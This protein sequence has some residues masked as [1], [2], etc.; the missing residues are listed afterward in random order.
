VK[1]SAAT[2]TCEDGNEHMVYT[3]AIPFTDFPG[4]GITLWY[5]NNTILLPSEY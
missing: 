4:A 3:K 2:L 1:D 5:T